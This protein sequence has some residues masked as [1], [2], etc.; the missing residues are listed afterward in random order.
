MNSLYILVFHPRIWLFIEFLKNTVQD[1]G[2][3]I[4]RLWNGIEITRNRKQRDIEND[5][6]RLNCKQ[7]ARIRRI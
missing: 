4:E 6:F 2:L 7:K 3:E 1:T 5:S